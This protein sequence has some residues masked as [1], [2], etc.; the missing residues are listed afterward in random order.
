MIKSRCRWLWLRIP[1]QRWS[2]ASRPNV[3]MSLRFK[4]DLNKAAANVRKHGVSFSEAVT[5]FSDPVAYTV[6]DEAHSAT[7]ER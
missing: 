3:A 6:E 4:R 2:E 5:V 1:G 7:E